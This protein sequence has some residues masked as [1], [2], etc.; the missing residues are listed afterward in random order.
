MCPTDPYG[1]NALVIPIGAE[2]KQYRNS[3]R[4][5]TLVAAG[6]NTRIPTASRLL[7]RR[8]LLKISELG[9]AM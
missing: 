1:E 3:R 2:E 4:F 6:S 9:V 5:V 8:T 7:I